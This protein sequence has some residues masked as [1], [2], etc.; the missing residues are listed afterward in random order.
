MS[1]VERSPRQHQNIDKRD[2]F[3][4]EVS[5]SAADS[6]GVTCDYKNHQPSLPPS[7]QQK[8]PNL[9]P[10]ATALVN[11]SDCLGEHSTIYMR[12]Q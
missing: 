7:P 8:D 10:K 5:L 12:N 11:N 6:A 4:A 3:G 1:I 2:R 9:G